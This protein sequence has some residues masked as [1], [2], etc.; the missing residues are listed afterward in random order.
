MVSM[1]LGKDVDGRLQAAQIAPAQAVY[2]SQQPQQQAQ[3]PLSRAK[4]LQGAERAAYEGPARRNAQPQGI[5]ARVQGAGK[6][7]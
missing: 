2:G 7:L 6:P 1:L 3:M 5:V 4:M